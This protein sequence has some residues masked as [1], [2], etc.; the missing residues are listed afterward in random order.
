[1]VVNHLPLEG[2]G[3]RAA[4]GGSDNCLAAEI[5][6]IT[7]PRH[8]VPTLPLKGRVYLATHQLRCFSDTEIPLPQKPSKLDRFKIAN[9]RRLRADATDAETKLWKHLWRIPIEGTHFAARFRSGA[10]SPISPVIRLVSSSS[11]TAASMRKT[12]QD[13]M[14]LSARPISKAKATMSSDSGM[15]RS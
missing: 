12:R 14:M 1:M 10:T 15:P 11:S 4:A 3:R 6:E 9:S 5:A 8:F 13:V 2:G 7:P